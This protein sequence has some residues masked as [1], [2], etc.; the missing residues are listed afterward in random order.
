MYP[1]EKRYVNL[2][3]PMSLVLFLAGVAVCEF[4]VIPKALAYLLGFNEWM[5]LENELRLNEWLT[6][7]LLMPIMCGLAFQT[8]L[9]M[10]FLE[11]LGIVNVDFYRKYR[12]YAVMGLASWSRSSP[13]PRTLSASCP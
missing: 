10:L 11:R 1:H 2:Y 7:A 4:I 13:L 8:P 5:G 12:R 9:V 6:F 3:L